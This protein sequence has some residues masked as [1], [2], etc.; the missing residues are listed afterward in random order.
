MQTA[1]VQ[2]PQQLHYSVQN[3]LWPAEDRSLIIAQLDVSF[4]NMLSRATQA[5]GS[6]G[7]LS[8]AGREPRLRGN[9]FT[10]VSHAGDEDN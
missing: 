3:L 1:S 5:V 8:E 10:D 2:T 9:L 6:W 7:D 4:C